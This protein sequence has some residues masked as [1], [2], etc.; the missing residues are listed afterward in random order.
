M[1][2]N[3]RDEIESTKR[4]LKK[5]LSDNPHDELN[6]KV[7]AVE[8]IRFILLPE[9]LN[10]ISGASLRIGELF[11]FIQ[12]QRVAAYLNLTEN[13]ITQIDE[14]CRRANDALLKAILSHQK[15]L[16]EKRSEL[17][18]ILHRLDEGQI[19]KLS[20][21]LGRPL[22]DAFFDSSDLQFMYQITSPRE[23]SPRN[24]LP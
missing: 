18:D 14:D 22:D 3:Q 11:K 17:L 21:L 12:G 10:S 8:K 13:Q 23:S 16:E 15:L 4:W 24:N 6:L 5:S 2:E 19:K 7:Q 9:Q 1:T 20:G